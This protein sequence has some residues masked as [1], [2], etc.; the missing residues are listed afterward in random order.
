MKLKERGRD[1][2]S[3]KVRA[4]SWNT[5]A[6]LLERRSREDRGT[7]GDLVGLRDAGWA[8]KRGHMPGGVETELAHKERGS[9]QSCGWREHPE[10]GQTGYFWGLQMLLVLSLP[11]LEA[12][13]RPVAEQFCEPEAWLLSA[14]VLNSESQE[15][16]S[17][18]EILGKPFLSSSGQ[19]HMNLQAPGQ[20]A[21]GG[22][23][24]VP[25]EAHFF[26]LP[27]VYSSLLFSSCSSALPSIPQ[28][29]LQRLH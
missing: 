27:W 7:Q 11:H 18:R 10:R 19:A 13:D 3:L 5:L 4:P 9:A 1:S 15:E 17:R 2:Q 14:A 16:F 25:G 28:S 26:I 12:L 6:V 29:Q 20:R 23:G 8:F 21:S 22:Q 24:Q